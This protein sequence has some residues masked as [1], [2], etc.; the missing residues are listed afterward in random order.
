MLGQIEVALRR[1][2]SSEAYR[3]LLKRL[4]GQAHHLQQ[5]VEMLLFLAR[6]ESEAMLPD[7]EVI[8]LAH[9]LG[10]QMQ[11]WATHPRATDMRVEAVNEQPVRVR[12]HSP[13]L[14]QLL[15][16]LL[17]NACKYSEP[18]T[19]ITLR[20]KCESS[21]VYCVVEDGGQG[22]AADELLHIFDPFYRSP[23]ARSHGY[24]GIG[25]GLAV[26]QRIA[27][28]FGGQLTAESC[29]GKGSS[30]TLCLPEVSA[31]PGKPG[32]CPKDDESPHRSKHLHAEVV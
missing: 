11:R 9:W 19:P 15:D 12:V 3:D 2:R 22:I 18:G 13:L 32:E 21:K 8:N 20:L 14:T 29:L 1:E 10:E 16:N 27:V 24:P 5:I 25:L 31:S 6:A 30:F 7:L 4:Q 23:R 26:A 17:D 28:S